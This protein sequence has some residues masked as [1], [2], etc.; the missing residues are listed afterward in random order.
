[1]H[2]GF[3]WGNMR[4]RGQWKDLGADDRI[5]LQNRSSRGATGEW[6]ELFWLRMGTGGGLLL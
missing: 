3:E 4:G 1:M 6:T 5:I 2:T